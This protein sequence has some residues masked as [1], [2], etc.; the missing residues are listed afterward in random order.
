[1]DGP[2]QLLASNPRAN[3]LAHK[4]EI[5][6]AIA[7]VLDSGR[8]IVG[9]EVSAFE[10]EFAEYVGVRF[11]V[12]VGS[13]TEALHLA[14]RAC[15]I[16]ENDEVI[17][18]SHTAVATVAA[19]ELCGATPVLVDIDLNTYTMD[20]NPFESS[21]TD[22][23]KAV[24][25]VHLYGHPADLQSIIGT[26]RRHNLRVIEDCGQSHG[27]LYQERMTG[28][29]GHLGAFSFYPT[30]NL[31]AMGDGG[32]VTTDDPELAERA[33]LLREYGWKER[34][35]SDLPGLN[36]RLDELQAA[37][38]RVKLR[39]LNEEN[40]KRRSL[41]GIYEDMLS[42]TSLVLPKCA[43]ET[44]HVYHQYV[45]RSGGRDG[46]KAFLRERGIGTLI[47]YPVPA[48]LQPAYRGRLRCA[49]SM[50][51]T[52]SVAQQVLSLPIYPE[53]TSEQIEQIGEAIVSWGL[54][55]RT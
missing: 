20:P 27:S 34:Y 41:A 5:D 10:N 16:G 42:T 24:I 3:Y 22:R 1:M 15:G 37:I 28:A 54:A 30:K 11:A 32:M 51:N 31:G 49:G 9:E 48:H 52:E 46:L 40:R 25:P 12:G 35:V 36:S 4:E 18:V 55:Q 17:T 43:P 23:T 14:L 2:G 29:H 45:V 19:I 38:L 47:H 7:R 26:A 39:Y 21:I 13:G 33:R 44:S 50:V 53:L 8:Y 6:K